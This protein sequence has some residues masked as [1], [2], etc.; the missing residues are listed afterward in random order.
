MKSFLSLER[1]ATFTCIKD[2]WKRK[3]IVYEG[4]EFVNYDMILEEETTE[5]S[6]VECSLEIINY[7]ERVNFI[8]KAKQKLAY[9]DT[10]V[11][12][13]DNVPVDSTISRNDI[14]QLSTM[15]NY[16][17][18]HLC[19]KDVVYKIDWDA[20][21]IPRIDLPIALRFGLESGLK[22]TPSRESYITNQFTKE[23]I[24]N[25]IVELSTYLI[26]KYNETVPDECDFIEGYD[27]IG[28]GNFYVSVDD[29][30]FL[31]NNLM[32]YSNV[33][34][35]TTAIT[36]LSFNP[37]S[38]YK[39]NLSR[40]NQVYQ[41]V[42][43]MDYYG[44]WKNKRIYK[45]PMDILSPTNSL[46]VI[47]VDTLPIGRVKSYLIEKYNKKNTLFVTKKSLRLSDYKSIFNL[48][49]DKKDTWRPII[50]EWNHIM[51]LFDNK[52]ISELGV[53]K[54]QGFL[55]YLDEQAEKRREHRKNNPPVKSKNSLNKQ[56][57]DITLA[58]SRNGLGGRIVFD[59]KAYPISELHKMKRYVIYGTDAEKQKLEDLYSV[60]NNSYGYKYTIIS[61]CI[62]GKREITKLPKL[63]NF[64]SMEKFLS[65]GNKKFR[66]IA[67]SQLIKETIESYLKFKNNLALNKYLKS[68]SDDIQV[69]S[70]YLLKN[71][72]DL[73]RNEDIKLAIMTL[74][75]EQNLWDYSVY[76]II[77]RVQDSNEVLNFAKHLAIPSDKATDDVK[78]E[79]SRIVNQFILF[80][81]VHKGK[82]ENFELVETSP[83]NIVETSTKESGDLIED[84]L[85]EEIYELL[86]TE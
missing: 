7:T 81:K 54:S 8:N 71:N 9:Y 76:H 32:K 26:N 1:P 14:F 53:D 62:I 55:D 72:F 10:A 46:Q 33:Q 21:E 58:L 28:R 20:L 30:N 80:N 4:A 64:I 63:H 47:L 19:L 38:Y 29:R 17:E 23:L 79:Y 83:Q 42:A 39:S 16:G 22:P 41:S 2:G 13:I 50:T 60:I 5:E 37:P 36:K 65:D 75:K 86:E 66:Q 3:Y 12:V 25:K 34:V 82:F 24:Y 48:R 73:T 74:A 59:K 11:L 84:E 68:I 40:L 77:K 51:S 27:L 85:T 18:I 45:S 15:N 61:T 35:K 67:T 44:Y 69:L 78:K 43:Y 70:Q 31:I 52:F 56:E 6:G 57:G 49:N